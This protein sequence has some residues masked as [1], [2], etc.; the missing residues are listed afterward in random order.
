MGNCCARE[1]KDS[2][3]K[4]V[5]ATPPSPV[6]HSLKN[7]G[8]CPPAGKIIPGE[9]IESNP[10]VLSNGCQGK[11]R[12]YL[13]LGCPAIPEDGP[14]RNAIRAIEALN[15]LNNFPYSVLKAATHRFD[16]KNLLGEGG[17]GQVFRGWIDGHTMTAAKPGKGYPVAIKKLRKEGIQG[18][19]EWLTELT[20]LSRF[21][22]PNVVK[23][24]GYCSE[25][26]ERILVYEYMT[27]GNLESHLIREK[28]V[29]LNWNKRVKIAVGAAKGLA[30]LHNAV[31]PVIH[32]DLKAS[33]IL[34]D[35]DFNAKLADF[36]LAKFGP[37]GSITHVSTRV[38]GTRGYFAPE[39]VATGHL[40]LKT[41][42]YSFGV[43]LLEIMSGSPAIKR[44]SDG[45]VCDLALWA[46]PYLSDNGELQCVID[47]KLRG[48]FPMEEAYE[49]ASIVLR[50]LDGNPKRRPTMTD[51]AT[52]L[53]QLDLKMNSE[54]SPDGN[55]RNQC[56]FGIIYEI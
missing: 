14:L 43:V 55:V 45:L 3:I 44:H 22:H 41:D 13:G 8:A 32:R 25:G 5:A 16:D 4:D 19:N 52:A 30:Y 49:Y 54:V 36:G 35:S 1:T 31:K 50:C 53:E 20:F 6:Y 48:K 24:I 34:L 2:T 23:L 28:G 17:F 46:K 40:T 15:K 18:D 38:L 21:N 26:N 51:V 9:A 10:S 27:R 33:N 11:P 42:V 37:Q 7:L 12:K 47:R 56:N 39:Y 29:V